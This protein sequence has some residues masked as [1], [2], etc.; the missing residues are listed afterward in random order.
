M[1]EFCLFLVTVCVVLITICIEVHGY[2]FIA[3]KIDE[4]NRIREIEHELDVIKD[5]IDEVNNKIDNGH[6]TPKMKDQ[7]IDIKHLLNKFG[8]EEID[9]TDLCIEVH[10]GF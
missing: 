2:K 9:P 4:E 1:I 5:K 8:V 6:L 3:I 10:R 7:I